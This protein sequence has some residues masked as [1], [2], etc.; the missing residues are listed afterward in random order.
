MFLRIVAAF[1]G[2]SPSYSATHGATQITPAQLDTQRFCA[3]SV[4]ADV[5]K[6]ECSVAPVHFAVR[7]ARLADAVRVGGALGHH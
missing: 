3:G 2:A 1:T 7:D 5:E 6:E 4:V